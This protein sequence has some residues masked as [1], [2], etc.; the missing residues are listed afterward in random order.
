MDRGDSTIVAGLGPTDTQWDRRSM[1]QTANPGLS[2]LSTF[3]NAEIED[4]T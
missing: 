2:P 3:A 4:I 1:G